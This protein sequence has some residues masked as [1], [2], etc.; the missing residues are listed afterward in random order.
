MPASMNL[1]TT[2]KGEPSSFVTSESG[3]A[4]YRLAIS[5]LIDA[6]CDTYRIN[7]TSGFFKEYKEINLYEMLERSKLITLSKNILNSMEYIVITCK[8]VGVEE[9]YINAVSIEWEEIL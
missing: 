1:L 2:T 4:S 5:D 9:N 7:I 8:S 3:N 6:E